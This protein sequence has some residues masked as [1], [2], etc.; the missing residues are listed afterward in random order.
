MSFGAGADVL[1]ADSVDHLVS[2]STDDVQDDSEWLTLSPGE[3]ALKV[4]L[5]T[6]GQA[7]FDG[8]TADPAT[9]TG[10]GNQVLAAANTCNTSANSMSTSMQ[11]KKPYMATLPYCI[12]RPLQNKIKPSNRSRMRL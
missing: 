10:S 9:V 12:S 6:A 11:H 5:Q 8:L 7:L 1:H 4:V 3:A 2:A